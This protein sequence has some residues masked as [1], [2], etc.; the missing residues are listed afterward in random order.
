MTKF[1]SVA[2]QFDRPALKR[3]QERQLRALLIYLER[4]SAFHRERF[5]ACGLR[6]IDFGGLA[7]LRRLPFT[8]K[9][10]LEA[11]TTTEAPPPFYRSFFVDRP[12]RV[13][14]WHRTSGT[15]GTPVRV[16]DTGW[17]WHAYSDVSA[18]ALYA[19]GVRREDTVVIPFGYGPFIA[20]WIY[21]SALE[22]I[23]AAFVASGSLDA[24]ARR[25]LLREFRATVLVSTPSYALH[26]AEVAAGAGLDLASASSVR[27]V[28]TT[29]EPLTTETKRRLT[30]VW[31]A[32]TFDRI[33]SAETGGIAYECPD[34]AGA[35]HVQE[36]HLVA[37]VVDPMTGAPVGPGEEGELVVTPLYRRGMPLVRF[38]TGNI[39]RLAAGG[40]C[41]CGREL[42]SL[43]VTENGVVLRRADMLVK[44]RGVLLDPAAVGR[45]VR[46][47]PECG[48]GFQLTIDRVGQLDE[49]TVTAETR[50]PLDSAR[51]AD[52]ARRLEESLRRALSLRVNVRVVELGAL[53]LDGNKMKRVL[54]RRREE[55]DDA[56]R[57]SRG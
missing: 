12:D 25:A 1:W 39:V 34:A 18:E 41:Q 31:G 29:G 35:Y 55:Q 28:I 40:R 33:G 30:S 48:E 50:L 14:R 3:L 51:R 45:A 43:A 52:V 13:L 53:A 46:G 16:A 15:T 27:L 32:E 21:I 20:F 57:T 11:D 17:D 49:A 56:V 44:V 54:D 23:G 38:R 36:N 2:E 7:D 19:M 47:V 22:Q 37:E 5:A 6:P 42:L 9:A 8:S 26:L 24:A 4:T 10:D